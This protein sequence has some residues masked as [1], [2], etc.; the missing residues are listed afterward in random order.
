MKTKI[1][2]L[3]IFGFGMPALAQSL[4][5]G[6]WKAQTSFKLNG[7]PLPPSD[8]EECVSKESAKDVKATISKELK[9]KGCELTK[10]KLK[11]EKLE[12]AL[13]C[14]SDDLNAKG[15]ITGKV[16]SKKYALNG[17]AEGTYKNMIPS[18]ATLTLNGQWDKPCQ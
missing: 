12:A 7:I 14:Q 9:K 8:S 4:T 10:W 11:G 3:S 15:K 2:L 5:P 1:I 18:S 17:E 16:T 6:V 13:T